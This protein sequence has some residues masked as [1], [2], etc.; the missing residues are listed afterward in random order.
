M[1]Y[2]QKAVPMKKRKFT[3]EDALEISGFSAHL[4]TDLQHHYISEVSADGT[5]LSED[6][7][8]A[9]DCVAIL[10]SL[11][12]ITN[13]KDLRTVIGGD[14]FEGQSE[15]LFQWL[16]NYKSSGSFHNNTMPAACPQK[17]RKSAQAV[18]KSI[19]QIALGVGLPPRPPTKKALAAEDSRIRSLERKEA[20]EK[21]A[22]D[23]IRRR[24]QISRIILDTKASHGI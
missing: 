16:M 13:V 22:A 2:P 10:A 19:S 8:L 15:W 12:H 11:D 9:D 23:L 24:Q 20:K 17:K 6:L 14:C 3:E 18:T 21:K 1:K 4:L 5:L 7:F